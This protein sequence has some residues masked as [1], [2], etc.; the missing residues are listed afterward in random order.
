MYPFGYTNVPL[1]VH[2]PQVGIL[3]ARR[4]YFRSRLAQTRVFWAFDW[5]LNISGSKVMI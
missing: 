4:K 3:Y 2:V 5:L 1:G